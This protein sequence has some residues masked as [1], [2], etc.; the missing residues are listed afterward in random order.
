MDF[1]R[2]VLQKLQ[3]QESCFWY[4]MKA[5]FTLSHCT[6]TNIRGVPIQKNGK[7]ISTFTFKR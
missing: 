3:S 5:V 7:E 2:C 1:L 4:Q 6:V